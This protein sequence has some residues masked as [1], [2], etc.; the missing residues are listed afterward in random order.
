[1]I[2]TKALS[3]LI[4]EAS[5]LSNKANWT[6]QDERRNA[7]LLSAIA[8]VKA[9]ASLLDVNQEFLNAEEQRMGLPLSKIVSKPSLLTVEQ[10]NQAKVFRHFVNGE[11]RDI[12][13]APMLS[14]IGTYSGLG[15]FVPTE[16]FN[17][18]FNSLKQYDFLFDDDSVTMIRTSNGRAMTVPTMSDTEIYCFLRNLFG[19]A[20]S[21]PRPR[22]LFLRDESI[23]KLHQQ[24][25]FS[26]HRSRSR[27]WQRLRENAWP[28]SCTRCV[29]RD[30][31][32]R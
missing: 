19:V 18:V 13:G 27:D 20:G 3:G 22:R 14:H 6:K 1:M 25:P 24:S 21:L 11:R 9:G 32:H 2:D 8:A 31:G 26:L 29:E 16:F 30:S 17:N 15:Y 7:F 12:E 4:Q 5:A 23:P 10:R 28:R